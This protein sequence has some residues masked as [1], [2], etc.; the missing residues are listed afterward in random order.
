MA[1]GNSTGMTLLGTMMRDKFIKYKCCESCS[2]TNAEYCACGFDENQ[3]QKLQLMQKLG[4]SNII[5]HSLTRA[6]LSFEEMNNILKDALIS[7]SNTKNTQT[8]K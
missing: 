8:S 3:L 6:N 4:F 2:N 5:C 1:S 7:I